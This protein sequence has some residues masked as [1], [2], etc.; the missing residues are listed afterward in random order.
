M[1]GLEARVLSVVDER[2]QL[3]C[4]RRNATLGGLERP[5]NTA[6]DHAHRARAALLVQG[7]KFRQLAG[8]KTLVGHSTVEAES[9][10]A[11]NVGRNDATCG[12][13]GTGHIAGDEVTG[14]ADEHSSGHVVSASWH[15]GLAGIAASPG[16]RKTI[17]RDWVN[18]P[19]MLVGN[20]EV[21][22]QRVR[23]AHLV[24]RNE[25]VAATA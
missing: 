16:Q 18:G 25:M 17:F 5:D 4:L 15:D 1:S 6:G 23:R 7:D 24:A 13:G 20:E 2:Q 9:E 8:A 10:G 21:A 22:V 3:L 19:L 14:G 11:R 12:V